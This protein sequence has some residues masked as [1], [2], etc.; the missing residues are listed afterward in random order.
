MPTTVEN[1]FV[2][3][4]VHR[5]ELFS[6]LDRATKQADESRRSAPRALPMVAAPSSIAP[7]AVAPLTEPAS[8][9]S[10]AF[11]L[12]AAV[13]LPSVAAFFSLGHRGH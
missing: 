13:A 5:A 6:A 3:S 11:A 1:L 4:P 10:N 9:F 2:E 12:V 8:A 7:D